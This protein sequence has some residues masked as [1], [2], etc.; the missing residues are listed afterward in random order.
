MQDYPFP[1]TCVLALSFSLLVSYER[2]KGES[3]G[4]SLSGIGIGERAERLIVLIVFSFLGSRLDRSRNCLRSG[5]RYFL[6]EILR[7]HEKT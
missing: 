3:L 2:A 4:I 7:D 6:A 5:V 1:I